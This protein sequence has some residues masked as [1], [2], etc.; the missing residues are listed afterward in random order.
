MPARVHGNSPVTLAPGCL[1]PGPPQRFL[2]ASPQR[3]QGLAPWTSG[4]AGWVCDL[5]LWGREPGRS[6]AAGRRL[7][8]LGVRMCP[9]RTGRQGRQTRR[10]L[11]QQAAAARSR[12]PMTVAEPPVTSAHTTAWCL[13]GDRLSG[14]SISQTAVGG[15]SRLLTSAA[16]MLFRP[17]C[18]RL[19]E[20][21]MASVSSAAGCACTAQRSPA[22]AVM[23]VA[24]TYTICL[25]PLSEPTHQT[26]S[27]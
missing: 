15:H 9:S 8:R 6:A 17:D 11:C 21:C 14:Y 12:H 27:H 19:R 10:A 7:G 20:R 24:G 25:F 4:L 23:H 26:A 22:L 18:L 13:N 1:V 16:A 3:A 5:G 2:G